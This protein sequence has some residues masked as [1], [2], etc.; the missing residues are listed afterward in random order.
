MARTLLR[1]LAGAALGAV[2][3]WYLTPVYNE[4]VAGPCA[5]I[6]RFDRR[7]RDIKSAPEERWIQFRS[8]SGRFPP[9]KI[10]ADQLTYNFI[11]YAGLIATDRRMFRDRH[12]VMTIIGI[13]VLFVA[14]VAA[15]AVVAESS[16]ATVLGDWSEAHYVELEARVWVTLQMFYRL[17]AMFAIPFAVWWW[18]RRSSMTI[19]V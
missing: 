8:A 19:S 10:P 11:L 1:F 5:G 6:L 7:L 13:V 12:V 9:V 17:L 2:V 16:F 18:P 15:F 4:V 14:H 3:W